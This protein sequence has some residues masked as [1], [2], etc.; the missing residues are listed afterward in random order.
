MEDIVDFRNNRLVPSNPE[1][2]QAVLGSVLIDPD[3]IILI[4]GWLRPDDFYQEKNGWIYQAVLDLHERRQPADFL[5]VTDALEAKRQLSEVGGPA[6]VMDLINAVPTAIHVEHYAR[7]VE[8]LSVLRKLIRAAGQ[9]AQMAYSWDPQKD[10]QQAVNEAETLMMNAWQGRSSG[11]VL[12][13]NALPSVID[14]IEQS[15]RNERSGVKTGFANLDQI[16]VNLDK[17]EVAVLAA[18]PG[19]GKSAL[20]MNIALNAARAGEVPA[21]F[22]LEMD[23]EVL[24]HRL[25]A[26]VSGINLRDIRQGNLDEDRW[27]RLMFA[28]GELASLPILIDDSPATFIMGLRSQAR[29]L[30]MQHGMTL[31][32]VDYLQL[33]SVEGMRPENRVQIVSSISALLKTIARELKVPVLALSQM[34]RAIE[35]RANSK[36]VLSDLRESGSLEQDAA[37]VIFLWRKPDPDD[38]STDNIVNVSVSKNRHGETGDTALFFHKDHQRFVDLSPRSV[39]RVPLNAATH[40]SYSGGFD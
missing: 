29:R 19:V 33:V 35:S 17:G 40:A 21:I 31:L 26:N 10:P 11:A 37:Q 39:E 14:G 25:L 12:V 4:S 18:R 22:S 5:T 9:V 24:V 30:K 23:Q 7:I 1:A 38:I 36:P 27:Q 13:G 8:R 16:L 32:I 28:A 34:S 2:E 3:A 15:S 6:Y 20:A